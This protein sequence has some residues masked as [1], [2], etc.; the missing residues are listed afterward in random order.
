MISATR[1]VST[2]SLIVVIKYFPQLLI[3]NDAEDGFNAFQNTCSRPTT[4]KPS[5][6]RTS[7]TSHASNASKVVE[8]D[9]TP[10]SLKLALASKSHIR[11][12][13]VFDEPFPR[14]NKISRIDFAWKTI[15]ESAVTSDDAE[16]HQAYKRAAEDLDSK[17]KLMK[18][19]SNTFLLI[20]SI[21][22]QCHLRNLVRHYMGALAL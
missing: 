21:F 7:T 5:H 4:T 2:P 19:V 16:I 11:M 1:F 14:N 9:F 15:R 13:T 6:P 3:N 18:F 20:F 8:K 10:R 22:L 17:S 12:R